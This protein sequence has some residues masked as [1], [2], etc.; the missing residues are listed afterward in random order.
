MLLANKEE[1]VGLVQ[2]GFKNYDLIK[3]KKVADLRKYAEILLKSA[4]VLPLK[5]AKELSTHIESAMSE[6]TEAEAKK[7]KLF[8]EDKLG[9]VLSGKN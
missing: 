9:K 8:M 5:Q 2:G 3:K 4:Q 7:M 6:W 1:L